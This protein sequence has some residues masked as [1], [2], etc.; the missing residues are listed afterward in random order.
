MIRWRSAIRSSDLVA[1]CLYLA[2]DG[3]KIMRGQ[4]LAADGGSIA[5]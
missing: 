4:I 2:S 5:W 1:A 3:A